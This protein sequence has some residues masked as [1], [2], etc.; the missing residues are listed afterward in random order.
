MESGK[1]KSCPATLETQTRR[2]CNNRSRR[3]NTF[4]S[5]THS[6]YTGARYSTSLILFTQ[7]L[8]SCRLTRWGGEGQPGGVREVAR[9]SLNPPEL[10]RCS[11][12]KNTLARM[13][14]PASG[15]R[16][17]GIQKEVGTSE[18]K[19]QP[20]RL[21]L[22]NQRERVEGAKGRPRRAK[23]GSQTWRRGEAFG[24]R[25]GGKGRERKE[26]W[27]GQAAV[28]EGARKG[29]GPAWTAPPRRPA[30][31]ATRLDVRREGRGRR[32]RPPARRPRRGDAA[33]PPR[34]GTSPPRGRGAPVS[35]S[36]AETAFPDHSAH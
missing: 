28:A 13:R 33:V 1:R 8:G 15:Q 19:R 25:G 32:C 7:K 21:G 27:Q 24:G 9:T 10:S 18:P 23:R 20:T 16:S 31:A 17:E 26:P 36:V 34:Q 22:E 6:T 29:A 35:R 14:W 30:P 4:T 2:S 5:L 12:L 3:Q 11:F